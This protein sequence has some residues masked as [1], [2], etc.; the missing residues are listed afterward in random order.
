MPTIT[1]SY[2]DLCNLIGEKVPI[3]KIAKLV[4]YG[5]GEFETYDEETDEITIGFGD[6]NLP[7]L[8]SVEGV[9][10]LLKG[11]LGKQKGNPELEVYKKSGYEVKVDE[12]VKQVRPYIAAFVA[13]GCKVN[14]YLIKQIIDLQE[15]F[16]ENY[17][18]RRKKAAIG[19]Y[20]AEKIKFPVHYK[21]T[22]KESLKF[23]PL[24][25]KKEMTQQEI[26]EEHPTGQ[27]YA[28]I[29]EGKEKYPILVDDNNKVLSFPPII[30]SNWSGKIEIGDE[31][32]FFE[33]TGEDL[34]SVLLAANLFAQAFYERGFKI[35]AVDIK[36]PEEK[37]TTP[38]I[39]GEQVKITQGQIRDLIGIELKEEE[40]KELLE[41]MQYEFK[42]WKVKIPDYRKDIMHPVDII[43][44]IAIAYGYDNI[45]M[46]HMKNYTQGKT[47]PIVDFINKIRELT[48]GIGYQEVMSAI[49]TNK[50]LM[51]KKMGIEDFG[52]A[53]IKEYISERFAIIRTWITPI[54]IEVLSKN[55]HVDYPQKIFEEGKVTVLKNGKLIDCNRLALINAHAESNYTEAKQALDLIM[56]ALGI[57][58]SVIDTEHRSFIPGRVGRVIVK[59]KKVGYIGEIN[60]AVLKNFD[61]NI[62]VSGFEINLTELF[63]T[64]N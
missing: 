25:F 35:Y 49:L 18:R 7:Y 33:A 30:N 54:L 47:F 15:K 46:L 59:E 23:V 63:E 20:N 16:C 53:E 17:G 31:N 6:T 28:W 3:E 2:K 45:E 61:L 10:R 42:N 11:L 41:K 44:D 8:W 38:L 36:Y 64:L 39:W 55:K 5:K 13:T 9:A 29:L 62:P 58:C 19:I 37:I 52:T 40:I 56:K 24:E 43:E 26:L 51:Y 12:T 32:L 21:A 27:K 1:F 22:E 57:K 34:D 14:D 60:P 50:E 48:I 4:S